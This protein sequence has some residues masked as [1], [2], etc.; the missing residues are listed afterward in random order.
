MLMINGAGLDAYY[1]LRTERAPRAVDSRREE[2]VAYDRDAVQRGCATTLP[3]GSREI[4]L[5]VDGL[6]CVACGWLVEQTLQ[7]IDGVREVRLNAATARLLLRWD[8]ERT[9]LSAILGELASLGYAPHPLGA[10]AQ[11]AALNRERRTLLKRL[12]VA[13][14]AMMQVMMYAIAVYVGDGL[15]LDAGQRNLFHW[16]SLFLTTPVVFYSA[17]PFFQGAWRGVRHG[18]PGMDLPVAIAI[19]LAYSASVLV[20]VQGGSGVYFDSVAMFTFFLLTGRWFE[21]SARHRAV[22]TGDAL[23]RLVPDTAERLAAD[24][25]A[26]FVGAVELQPGDKVRVRAGDRFPCDGVIRDG[27]TSVDESLLTG[28]SLPLSRVAGEAVIAG[29]VNLES[30]VVVAVTHAGPDTVVAGITRLLARAQADRPPV[31]QLAD[32]VARWFVIVM[33]VVA[34]GVF[35][36]WL[37]LDPAR[38]FPIA[39]AVLVVAC[40]CALALATP[41]ALT[42]GTLAMARHGLLVTRAVALEVLARVDTMVFDKTGTLTQ[43]ALRVADTKLH[44]VPELPDV[45]SIAAALER[46]SEHPIAR[47]FRGYDDGRQVTDATIERHIG[48]SGIVDGRYYELHGTDVGVVLADENGAVATFILTDTLRPGIADQLG[49]LRA[50]GIDLD[51]LSGDNESTVTSIAGEVG[52]DHWLARQTPALKLANV[53]ALQEQSLVVAA[54]GDGVNDAPVLAAA[55]VGIAMRSGAA[56][57]QS[58]ADMMLLGNTLAPLVAGVDL[59]RRTLRTIRQNLG[60][61]LFYNLGAIPLAAIGWIP[62]WAAA[63]G[64]AA[65]SL[66][67]VINAARLQRVEIR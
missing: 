28:E 65:S 44:A 38:A 5:L 63:L 52:I 18:A 1:R 48:V 16:I 60:L 11:D 59:S 47:A 20:T 57:A 64:M 23:V 3:D 43:G 58:S 55:D 25:A 24:G 4:A 26:M 30:P 12:W 33:L 2:W 40:P 41:V 34:A 36:T 6:R 66:V 19:A 10:S 31:A 42:A 37:Q 7:R 51:I 17:A 32:R 45:L 29:S 8:P 46:A 21:L 61:S 14:L 13:G 22:R 27:V 50:R 49:A 56:L 9:A 54:V 35:A 53:Q 62:P 39:L 67:V 15:D